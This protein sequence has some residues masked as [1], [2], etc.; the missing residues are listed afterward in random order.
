MSRGLEV[1]FVPGDVAVVGGYGLALVAALYDTP[2]FG[3]CSSESRKV[4]TPTHVGL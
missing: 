2:F 4:A 1:V 3:V